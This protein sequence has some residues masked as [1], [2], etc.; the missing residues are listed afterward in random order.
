MCMDVFSPGCCID[1]NYYLEQIWI[2]KNTNARYQVGITEVYDL[3]VCN[4]MGSPPLTKLWLLFPNDYTQVDGNNRKATIKISPMTPAA[5]NES[6]N[7]EWFYD[8]PPKRSNGGNF[9]TRKFYAEP[10]S[11]G[12]RKYV[13]LKG[14]ILADQ[15]DDIKFPDDLG[16]EHLGILSSPAINKT[17]VCVELDT[18]LQGAEKGWIRIIANPQKLE[19]TEP[20]R[21]RFPKVSDLWTWEYR[22]VIRCPIIVR[23]MLDLCLDN[24][25]LGQ[26]PT[27]CEHIRHVILAN[28]A[29]SKGTSTRITDHRIV[30][31]ATDDFDV[32]D[33]N[34]AGSM[35]Y[36]GRV[37]TLEESGHT[38]ILWHGGSDVNRQSDL[39]HNVRR[40]IDMIYHTGPRTKMEL[41]LAL[42]P[43]G[44]HEA[45]SVLIDKMILVG[46]LELNN[47]KKLSL[48]KG[49]D[50]KAPMDDQ[51]LSFLRQVYSARSSEEQIG[52]L[53]EFTDL[54]PFQV[55]FRLKWFESNG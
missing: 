20:K 49:L 34:S 46:I 51:R 19:A 13:Y 31:I 47:E 53:L 3:C 29:Y 40:S 14:K 2:E 8:E 43:S 15:N 41:T 21:K 12:G 38:A 32:S 45:F 54:H 28:G 25:K 44:K 39:L 7:Y 11:L 5:C 23:Q 24:P 4:C 1:I 36:L 35:K 22:L 26:D 48:P 37:P 6:S 42:S 33:T 55:D 52:L 10:P 16:E 18:P 30:L 27:K 17:I 9:V 50:M